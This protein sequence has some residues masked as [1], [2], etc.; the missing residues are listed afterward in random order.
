MNIALVTGSS[1]LIGSE[2]V[3]FFTS[4]F[5]QVIGIDNNLREYF[6]GKEASVEW[7]RKR[8][9]ERY[10]NFKTYTA[11]IREISSLESIFSKY[12][13]DIKLILHTAA[14]P[15]HDWAAKEPFTDF[16]VNAVGTLN[17]LEMCRLH[18]P[19]AVFIFTSTNKVYGDT[20][21]S[22]PLVELESRWEID[23]THPYY[24]E[25]IDELMSIDQTKHS[26]FG[27]SKVAGDVLVQE[28]GR[29][30]EMKTGVFRGGCLTGPNHSGAQLHGFLAYLMKC[31]ITKNHYTIFGYKGKQVRDNI[32][33]HDLVQM[34]W[35]FYQ[36]PRPGEVYNA[37]GG[38]FANC[39][40]LEAIKLCEEIS[41][42]K[43][44]YSYKES[45]RI[46]DHIWWISDVTKF[47]KHYPKWNWEYDLKSTLV[48]MHA[49]M[50]SRL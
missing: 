46:G 25:G 18:C 41:G 48:Q 40:M 44:D 5:D 12:G 7:N 34:F 33:S 21:N 6:F 35:N 19:Q 43:M 2:A 8:L 42:N 11:D 10:S 39:S 47:K 24:K 32:H 38:R 4:Q 13:S 30:F 16:S 3:N 27:A 20:P 1:G 26:L 49:S 29:Y 31:A 23:K 17:M 37:G 9:E 28:Y 45:N 36:N 15:S 14:Q 22:L 50:S